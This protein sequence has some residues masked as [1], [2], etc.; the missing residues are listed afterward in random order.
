MDGLF[1]DS[2]TGAESDEGGVDQD[3]GAPP[4]TE[5]GPKGFLGWLGANA[6]VNA[7]RSSE[8]RQA[9][10]Q[11]AVSDCEAVK[12][13]AHKACSDANRIRELI[14]AICQTRRTIADK[15]KAL[16]ALEQELTDAVNQ[17]SRLDAEE[18]R[19]ANTALKQ[20]LDALA[21]HQTRKPGFLANLF[22]QWRTQRDWNATQALLEG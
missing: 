11:Q 14:Q 21:Q 20:C 1:S 12:A 2:S 18:S 13:E 17:L 8:E 6:E 5:K 19:P 15:S 16:R 9:L 22:S 3:D 4:A 10:W 7:T